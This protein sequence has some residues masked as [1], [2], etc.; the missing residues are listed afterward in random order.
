MKLETFIKIEGLQ[1]SIKPGDNN[2][3]IITNKVKI[4]NKRSQSAINIKERLENG[5]NSSID[6]GN[7]KKT[8]YNKHKK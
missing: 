8:F 6:K 4:N 2:F 3:D 1:I 5:Y 7:A